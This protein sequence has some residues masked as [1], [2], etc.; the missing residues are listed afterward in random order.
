MSHFFFQ[1]NFLLTL[2][3]VVNMYVYFFPKKKMYVYFYHF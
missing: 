3:M 1:G 2:M